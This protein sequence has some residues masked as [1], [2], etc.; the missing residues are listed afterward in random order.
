MAEPVEFLVRRI[1]V[2]LDASAASL[3]ALSAAAALARRLGSDLR[4]LFVE[5]QDLLR[6]AGLPFAQ[7][8]RSP[9]GGFDRLVRDEVEG[10]LRALAA[11]A[12]DA[13]ERAA[14]QV[15]VSWSFEVARGAVTA[16]VLASAGE[17][18]L[19]VLGAGGH[20][21]SGRAAAG[22]TARAAARGARAS[23]LLLAR[24]ARMG[25]RVVAVHDGS[26]G[27]AR[28]VVAAARIA[29]Q[30]EP[31]VVLVPA[32]PAERAESLAAEARALGG[33]RVRVR[34]V[35][36]G[37]PWLRSAI[38]ELRPALLALGAGSTALSGDGL[39]DLL[40]LGAPVLL[41]RGETAP[42]S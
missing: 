37:R 7:E 26:A 5:D 31:P 29:D 23:V 14:A 42:G 3:D 1:V 4:A 11:R 8:T 2:G 27:S 28:A 21:R 38:V 36:P 20:L 17:E 35:R 33:P 24:G 6:L 22:G 30:G 16:K 41:V 34:V 10:Q 9:A 25:S 18:D 13:L 15:Q 32:L 40:A 19:L 12:R 39:E